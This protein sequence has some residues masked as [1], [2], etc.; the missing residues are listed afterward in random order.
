MLRD[1]CVEI[2]R[3]RVRARFPNVSLAE[4]HRSLE[5]SDCSPDRRAQYC[6]WIENAP[7]IADCDAEG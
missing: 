3:R 5:K 7:S 1:E 4:I 2:W 6:E